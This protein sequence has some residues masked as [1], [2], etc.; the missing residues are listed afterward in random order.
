MSDELRGL[1][2]VE[3]LA[4]QHGDVGADVVGIGG[5][6]RAGHDDDF[7]AVAAEWRGAGGGRAAPLAARSVRSKVIVL[8][9]RETGFR[10][11]IFG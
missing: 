4:L 11:E 8:V 5:D 10:R 3:I 2:D 6:A 9:S 1:L 7:V